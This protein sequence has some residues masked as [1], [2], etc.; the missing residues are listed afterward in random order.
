M[1]AILEPLFLDTSILIARFVHGPRTKE[2]IRERIGQHSRTVTSVVARREFKR[3]LLREAE[4]LLRML[5]RYKSFDEVNQH[6]IQLFGQW[7][8]RKRNICLQTLSQLHGGTDEE[9]TERLQLYLRSLLV[10]GLRRLDQQVDQVRQDSGCACGRSDV[11]EKAELRKYDFGPK[12]CSQSKAPCG[13]VQFLASRKGACNGI[14]EKLRSLPPGAKSA[15]LKTAEHFLEEMIHHPDRARSENACDT[16]GDVLIGLESLGIPNF[17]TLNST[18]SQHL[19]RALDQTMIVRHVDPLKP[20]TVCDRKAEQWPV[21][22][23][24][25]QP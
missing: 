7:H 10:D 12:N 11:F 1:Q 22:G 19:C 25:A 5:H 4:Y 9:R 24:Q 18:E 21:F 20:D 8:T 17:Y 6:V 23:K 13:I 14:L 3:R 16:V 15:E 2:R